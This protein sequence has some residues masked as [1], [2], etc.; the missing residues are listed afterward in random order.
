VVARLKK[1]ERRSGRTSRRLGAAAEAGALGAPRGHQPIAPRRR[2]GSDDWRGC[3]AYSGVS[4]TPP[5][6]GSI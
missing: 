2:T 3:W 5:C 4:K 1:T 6:S